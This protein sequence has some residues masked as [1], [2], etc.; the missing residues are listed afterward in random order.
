MSFETDLRTRLVNDATVAAIVG[1]RVYWEVR[2]QGSSLPAIVMYL[3]A[4][5]RDQHLGGVMA[6]QGNQ[7]QFDCIAV[8]KSASVDLRQAVIAVIEPRGTAGATEFQ[9]GNVDLFRALVEDTADGLVRTEQ[10][11]ATI[12]FN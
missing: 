3:I 1:T 12:W 9:G 2:P 6:T 11:R 7:V 5:E 10:V 8:S 4:G